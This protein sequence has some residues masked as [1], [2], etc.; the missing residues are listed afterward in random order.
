VLVDPLHVTTLPACTQAAA[1]G[2]VGITT[3]ATE[4]IRDAASA[5][6]RPDRERRIAPKSIIASYFLENRTRMH[7][8]RAELIGDPERMRLS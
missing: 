8:D 6:D 3:A 2:P 1:A 4:S 7:P 5:R